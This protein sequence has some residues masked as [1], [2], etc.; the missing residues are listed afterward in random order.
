MWQSIRRLMLSHF[1][2]HLVTTGLISCLSYTSFTAS[3]AFELYSIP[4][5]NTVQ[6]S[7][8]VL[9]IMCNIT[10]VFVSI[11]GSKQVKCVTDTLEVWR[12]LEILWVVMRIKYLYN[13]CKR[14][15]AILVCFIFIFFIL[16]AYSTHHVSSRSLHSKR[17][18]RFRV[19]PS[20]S[21]QYHPIS[22]Y[23]VGI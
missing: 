1:E 3:A 22:P 12:K 4:E 7:G 9:P 14:E 10:D 2:C 5:S 8:V 21:P 6:K 15:W 20:N 18:P 11:N 19:S 13:V 16:F 17:F 23:T